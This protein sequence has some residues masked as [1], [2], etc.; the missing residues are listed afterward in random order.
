MLS[1]VRV[2]DADGHLM[3]FDDLVRSYLGRLCR[4]YDG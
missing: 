4:D 1:N 3:D 2:I